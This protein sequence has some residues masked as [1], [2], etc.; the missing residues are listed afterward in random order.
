MSTVSSMAVCRTTG[1]GNRWYACVCVCRLFEAEILR[2]F[3]GENIYSC[4]WKTGLAT[5]SGHP[6]DAGHRAMF[7]AIDLSIF[8]TPA[9][10]QPSPPSATSE[11]T[12]GDAAGG[13]DSMDTGCG[14]L[15]V[16]SMDTGC[17][18]LSVDS[19]D[20]GCGSLGVNGDNNNNNWK[21]RL[22]EVVIIEGLQSA[23]QYN[24]KPGMPLLNIVQAMPKRVGG[25]KYSMHLNC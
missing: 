20:T 21:P 10:L 18:S 12:H 19:M 6:N 15:S 7:E 9:V 11:G 4:H 1:E 24:G 14:S 17:G 23:A 16:N 2:S 3:T 8:T 5:D 22:G 13:E 25:E